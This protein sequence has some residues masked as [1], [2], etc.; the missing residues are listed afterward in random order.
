M[1]VGRF[2][3]DA[4]VAFVPLHAACLLVFWVPLMDAGLVAGGDLCHSHVWGHRGIS[5]LFQP[6]FFRS[7]G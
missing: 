3:F 1:R 5:P 7:T 6:S 2:H 4:I